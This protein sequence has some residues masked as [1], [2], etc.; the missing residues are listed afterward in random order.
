MKKKLT[1]KKHKPYPSSKTIDW[2]QFGYAIEDLDAYWVTQDSQIVPIEKLRDNHLA[3]ILIFMNQ[4]PGWRS[5]Q[6]P[7]LL[8]EVE[9]RKKLKLTKISKAGK[10]FY[11]TDN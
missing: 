7:R 10:L 11:G 4:R 5:E 6:R 8:A 2:E 1:Q 9:R 3:A